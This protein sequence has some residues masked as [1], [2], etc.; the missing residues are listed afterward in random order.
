MKFFWI[1]KNFLENLMKLFVF[2]HFKLSDKIFEKKPRFL[3][4][5]LPADDQCP[6]ELERRHLSIV[7]SVF[8]RQSLWTQ[9]EWRKSIF[10]SLLTRF[11]VDCL[12]FRQI[13]WFSTNLPLFPLRMTKQYVTNCLQLSVNRKDLLKQIY[14]ICF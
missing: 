2:N 11:S 7:W 8:A 3:E 10:H 4:S 14:I 5:L 6:F 13:G 1:S 9:C 12:L